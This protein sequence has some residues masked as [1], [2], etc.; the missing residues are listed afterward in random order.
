MAE[1]IGEMTDVQRS[2]LTIHVHLSMQSVV[3]DNLM[4]PFS[5]AAGGADLRQNTQR[6][7]KE[8]HVDPIVEIAQMTT[9]A[10]IVNIN[11]DPRFVAAKERNQWKMDGWG[12]MPWE[13]MSLWNFEFA[14]A[15]L[16]MDPRFGR[17]WQST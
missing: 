9:R 3:L 7:L 11:H 14:D 2:T 16:L 15:W 12:F 1:A 10:P 17:R 4:W 8:T 5:D 6:M 13:P